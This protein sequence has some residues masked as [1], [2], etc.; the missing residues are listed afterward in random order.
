MTETLSRLL[1]RLQICPYVCAEFSAHS[2]RLP[3]LYS[4]SVNEVGVSML[5]L[6]R[7]MSR[8]RERE[9]A[10]T[11]RISELKVDFGVERDGRVRKLTQDW[12]SMND[13]AFLRC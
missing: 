8:P 13:I 6:P 3:I 12:E 7:M 10:C 2:S 9:R 11:T 4:M 1:I 5:V